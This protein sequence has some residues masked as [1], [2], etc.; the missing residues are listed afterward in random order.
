[1]NELSKK[2]RWLRSQKGISQKELARFLHCSPSTVSN[3]ENA[4][5]APGLDILVLLADFYEVSVDYL[6]GRTFYPYPTELQHKI[7]YGQYTLS[8]FLCL[9][10]HLTEKDKRFLAYGFRLLE[11]LP[12]PKQQS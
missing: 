12:N 2:L 1:M 11:K 9:L 10:E 5:Y 8:Q 4:V 6:L 7:I 3:Y